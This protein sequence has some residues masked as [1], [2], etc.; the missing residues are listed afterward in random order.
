MRPIRVGEALYT[1][2]PLACMHCGAPDH[3]RDAVGLLTLTCSGKRC[4]KRWLALR[5]PPGTT[6]AVLLE[7]YGEDVARAIHRAVCPDADGCSRDALE[8]W[9]LPISATIA[10][11]LQRLPDIPEP[12]I[13]WYRADRMLRSLMGQ[14]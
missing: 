10:Q 8:A 9:I 3:T 12:L 11:Y 14:R 1:V 13:G 5:L 4:R 6:G 7:L 2:G